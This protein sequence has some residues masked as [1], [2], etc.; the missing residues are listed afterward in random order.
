MHAWSYT[1]IL[2]HDLLLKHKD[3]YYL[4]SFCLYTTDRDPKTVRFRTLNMKKNKNMKGEKKE[5][6]YLTFLYCIKG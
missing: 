2:L 4:I 5:T 6:F 1:A 3:R